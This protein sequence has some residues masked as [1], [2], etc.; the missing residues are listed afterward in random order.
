MNKLAFFWSKYK[1][2]ILINVAFLYAVYALMIGLNLSNSND[3]VWNIYFFEANLREISLGRFLLPVLDRLRFG[4]VNTA[5]NSILF[6]LSLSLAYAILC[7]ALDIQSRTSKYLLGFVFSASPVV[8]DTL[9]YQ[10]TTVSYGIGMLFSAISAYIIV[11][12]LPRLT[13]AFSKKAVFAYLTSG[14]FIA[15][16]MSCYQAYIGIIFLTVHMCFLKQIRLLLQRPEYK[17]D[18]KKAL[19]IPASFVFSLIF[20]MI[21]Y[22][23][24][25]AINR[26]IWNISIASYL[27]ADEISPLNIA[28]NLPLSIV[29]CYK[30]F[31]DYTLCYS[32]F[33]YGVFCLILFIITVLYIS[34]VLCAAFKKNNHSFS[35]ILFLIYAVFI[36]LLPVSSAI[37]LVIAPSAELTILMAGGVFIF[38]AVLSSLVIDLSLNLSRRRILKFLPVAAAFLVLWSNA[39]IISNDQLS[40][41]QGEETVCTM[42][43][44][45][46]AMAIDKGYNICEIPVFIT[47][48]PSDSPMFFKS[49]AFQKANPYARFGEF[50]GG[51]SAA[52]SWGGVA[53]KKLGLELN[54]ITDEDIL[55][56]NEYK[57]MP[58]FPKE[59]SMRIINDIL[60]IKVAEVN[61]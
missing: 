26:R 42:E 38:P 32:Y 43:N 8:C 18:L 12:G 2:Y 9:S 24:F 10:Y 4:I 51:N 16:S 59:G 53:R 50:W 37:I 1:Y 35:P 7:E 3:G 36:L 31:L 5:F 6:F 56:A 48:S 28:L 29:S 15:L 47:G 34:V 13:P 22:M 58:L 23:L 54:L 33:Y 45:M 39:A 61:P 44:M 60:V 25:Y 17:S 40:M 11:K 20:G 21:I 41:M 49:D 19:Y 46:V 57:N 55:S 52:R 14:C 27:G 30:A